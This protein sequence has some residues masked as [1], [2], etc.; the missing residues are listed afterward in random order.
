MTKTLKIGVAGLGTV[1]QSVLQIFR[2][3]ASAL[4]A[5]S[6]R[7][8]EITGV[9]A[10]N[11]NKPRSINID[12]LNW[13]DDP[14]HLAQNQNID[15]F[16]ELI[17][18]VTGP[19]RESVVAALQSGKD[20]VTANK[21]L[22]ALH[23][24]ELAELAEKNNCLLR[25]EA[26]VAGCIPAIKVLMESMAANTIVSVT[27]IMN[28]TC[29]YILT[30]MEQEGLSYENVFNE[31]DRLGYL[32]ADPTLDV[33]GIDAGHKLALLASIAFGTRVDFQNMD[34]EG[35]E[36][37]SIVDIEQARDI[38]FRIKLLGIARKSVDGLEQRTQPC[39]VPVNSPL[40]QVEG[41]TN[42]IAFNG[43]Y[44]E[45]IYLR[46]A[47]AGGG[48]TASAVLSDI[49]DIARGRRISTFGQN[50]KTLE[51]AK[52]IR[53]IA[54]VPYYLRLLLVDQPGVL[55]R[56][57]GALGQ[58]GVSINRMRQY[59]HQSNAAPVIIV[60]HATTRTR[61]DKAMNNIKDPAVSLESPVVIRIEE[62]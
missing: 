20:V 23:G 31:A 59:S 27:G 5:R 55:A 53:S 51:I 35:I 41:A 33:G 52:P 16:V 36:R 2:E 37:I 25:F 48:P 3:N 9:S 42:I 30:R 6:G 50:A 15:V 45:Q 46:G 19:A 43:D 13:V 1:G 56:V 10:K 61:L 21:A 34:I 38:G 17:G 7:I 58:E 14:V 22:M 32:E 4:K 39:L 12:D 57:A 29:N 8:L 49:V 44:T 40:A 18:G 54:P 24:Q 28:G 26:A 47:G 60:T 11:H 62:F